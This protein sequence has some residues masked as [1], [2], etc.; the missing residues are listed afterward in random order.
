[1]T[2]RFFTTYKES[3]HPHGYL[4]ATKRNAEWQPLV[5]EVPDELC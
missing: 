5:L 4:S 3:T 2:M 1:M